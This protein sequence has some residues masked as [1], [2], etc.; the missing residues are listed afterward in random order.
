MV[1]PLIAVLTYRFICQTVRKSCVH[2]ALCTLLPHGRK[3]TF[4]CVAFPFSHTVF[5]LPLNIV[6]LCAKSLQSCLTLCDPMGCSEPDSSVHGILQTRMLECVA[7]PSSRGSPWLTDQTLLSYLLH[8]RRIIYHW[9]T[10]EAF[11]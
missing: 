8:Y 5:W 9:T 7:M 6:W 1:S 2:V 10:R 3:L 4:K 11:K